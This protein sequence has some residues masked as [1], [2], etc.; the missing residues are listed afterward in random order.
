MH[1]KDNSG[2]NETCDQ[3]ETDDVEQSKQ[4]NIDVETT[5]DKVKGGMIRGSN[6]KEA[7]IPDFDENLARKDFICQNDEIEE[8]REEVEDLLIHT[9]VLNPDSTVFLKQNSEL[10]IGYVVED[11]D[12]ILVSPVQDVQ[13]NSSIPVAEEKKT[14]HFVEN[15]F[16]N[17]ETT[18]SNVSKGEYLLEPSN[19]NQK[20][21]DLEAALLEACETIRRQEEQMV[22]KDQQISQIIECH[23]LDKK[24]LELKVKETKDEAKK[25]VASAK[26]KVESLKS[27]LAKIE[28]RTE[29][30][31]ESSKEKDEIIAALRNEGEKLAIKQ[32]NMEQLIK[33]ARWDIKNLKDEL[34]REKNTRNAAE[35]KIIDLEIELKGT[36]ETL[37][38]AQAKGG[39]VEKLDYDLL[40]AKEEKEKHSLMLSKL[41]N[42]L[43]TARAANLVLQKETDAR[44]EDMLNQMESQIAATTK[45][46]EKMLNDLEIKLNTVER[47][48]S[49]RED[50]LRQ[51]VSELRKRWQESVRRCD[52]MS[53]YFAIESSLTIIFCI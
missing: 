34:E 6:E 15:D 27:Q 35:K 42:E 53:L 1:D 40:A 21:F 29:N 37:S 11:K 51:E 43:K 36:K 9:E 13:D 14:I 19:Y 18:S 7:D 30:S 3:G 44:L 28:F 52:G 48:S 39:L 31:D 26:E 32:S 24:A 12:I 20:P 23:K 4:E 10:D 41:E 45:E 47:E 16:D 5:S 2:S 22:E 46:K 25:R 8:T 33:D 49:L 50:S 17:H 38:A